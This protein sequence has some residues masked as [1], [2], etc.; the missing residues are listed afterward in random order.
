MFSSL[1]KI[2][3]E[4]LITGALTHTYVEQFNK[5]EYSSDNKVS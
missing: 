3:L 1:S 2:S 4:M 5:K